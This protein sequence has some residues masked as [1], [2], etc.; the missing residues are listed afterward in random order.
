PVS[1]KITAANSSLCDEPS[2]LNTDSFG[3]AW[4]VEIEMENEADWNALLSPEAYSQHA[5]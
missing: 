4:L 2:L 5:H 1:G 3:K